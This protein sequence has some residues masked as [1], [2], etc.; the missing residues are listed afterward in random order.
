MDTTLSQAI[1]QAQQRN[2]GVPPTPRPSTL[3][4]AASHFMAAGRAHASAEEHAAFRGELIALLERASEAAQGESGEWTLEQWRDARR[5]LFEEVNELARRVGV[6]I[7]TAEK[8]A[9]EHNAYAE[10]LAASLEPRPKHG[11][12]QRLAVSVVA[13]FRAWQATQ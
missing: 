1:N 11:I 12:G 6:G 10:R 4:E 8:A 5:Y 2:Y 9:A 13:A 7:P 3:R